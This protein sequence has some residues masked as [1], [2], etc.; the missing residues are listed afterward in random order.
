M[1]QGEASAWTGSGTGKEQLPQRTRSRI[2]SAPLLR[3]SPRAAGTPLG[4]SSIG[5]QEHESARARRQEHH[6]HSALW[7]VQ[8]R[9]GGVLAG[10]MITL[11]ALAVRLAG[12][13][14]RPSSEQ[15][16]AHSLTGREALSL[17]QQSATMSTRLATL[18]CVLPSPTVSEGG[19]SPAIAR[20]TAL[21]CDCPAPHLPAQPAPPPPPGPPAWRSGPRRR[22]PRWSRPPPR[23]TAPRP[24]RRP[25]PT[26]SSGSRTTCTRRAA[27]S[28]R[29]VSPGLRDTSLTALWRR[30][31]C[32]SCVAHPVRAVPLSRSL[33]RRAG[34]RLTK[35]CLLS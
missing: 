32:C 11:H 18:L 21:H 29:H 24:R 35:R 4:G 7:P 23:R 12:E 28:P 13:R 27:S 19:T 1:K 5:A 8:Q 16:H 31:A 30:D 26:A 10:L 6:I 3:E 25:R 20:N 15:S 33:L 34:P 2:V 9:S 14:S 17:I 22:P